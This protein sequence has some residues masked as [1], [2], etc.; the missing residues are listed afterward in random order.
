MCPDLS[1]LRTTRPTE[2]HC[3]N[4]RGVI[5]P[6]SP[7]QSIDVSQAPFILSSLDVDKDDK[8]SEDEAVDDMKANFAMLD[9]NGYGGID[10]AELTAILKMVATQGGRR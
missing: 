4:P 1:P 7:E 5:G 6:A 2:S 9:A 10:L 3:L 8:I